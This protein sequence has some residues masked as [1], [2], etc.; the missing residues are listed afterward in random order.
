MEETEIKTEGMS[1]KWKK[2]LTI[3]VIIMIIVIGII[4]VLKTQL[5]HSDQNS[6]HDT[7]KNT[8]TSSGTAISDGQNLSNHQCE[9]TDKKML[10][11]LPMSYDDFAFVLPYGLMIDGHVTPIDHQYFSPTIFNSPRD[12]YPVYA[13]ADAKIVSLEPRTTDRGT[14]YRIVFSISCKLFYYYDLVTSLAPEIMTHW[15]NTKDKHQTFTYQVKAG[16]EIG[17]IG[18]QTLD[19]AVWDMDKNLSGFVKP[20]HYISESWKVHTVDPLDYYTDDLRA[21]IISKYLRTTEPRSGKIDYDTDG[22]LV[23]TWFLQGTNFYNGLKREDYWVGHLSIAYDY[24]D[25][26]S[27]VISTGDYGGEALQFGVL[28][29]VPDPKTIDFSTGMIK[30][31]L[32]QQD[33]VD[34]DGQK[35]DRATLKQGIKAKNPSIIQGVALFQLQ[36]EGTLKAEFFPNQTA[37]QA[38]NFTQNAKIFER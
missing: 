29:N 1:Q 11:H 32:V 26:T 20:E 30:Y 21:K 23:G 37:S 22:K 31:E 38:D 35:W 10:T 15:E 8:T 28:N 25:P 34:S 2:K 12:S 24:L 33:W 19:F 27:I 7:G 6:N 36:S 3:L 13:M 14:E 5:S 16:D 9:G 18:G 17:K 4:S